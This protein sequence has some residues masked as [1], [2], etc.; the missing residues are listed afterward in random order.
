M[1]LA[2]PAVGGAWEASPR[3]GAGGG[4]C[5]LPLLIGYRAPIMINIINSPKG[6]VINYGKG[7]GGLQNGKIVGPKLFAPPPPFNIWLKLQATV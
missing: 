1:K 4:G 7:G 2:K 6:L 3:K 5:W